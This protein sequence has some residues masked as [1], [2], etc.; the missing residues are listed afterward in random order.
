MPP[1][2][3]DA[4]RIAVEAHGNTQDKAGR[5]PYILHPMRV[6]LAQETE[7][8]RMVGILHDVVED[9]DVSMD[10]IVAMGF[11]NEVVEALKLVTHDDDGL[12][13]EEYINRLKDN[14]IARNVK[15]ADLEDNMNIRR[16]AELEAKDYE[17][18]KKY[19]VTWRELKGL[20]DKKDAVLRHRS[21]V[22]AKSTESDIEGQPFPFDGL[23]LRCLGTVQELIAGQVLGAVWLSQCGIYVITFPQGYVPEFIDKDEAKAVGN[24]IRPWSID[25]LQ[26]KWVPDTIVGYIGLAGRRQPRTLSERLGDLR[27][28]ASGKTTGNGPHKGGEIIWQLKG[29]MEFN[30]WV[31]PT[32]MPPTPRETEERLLQKF[33]SRHGKLPFA[34]RQF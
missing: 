32:G 5:E 12:S 33:H 29:H 28:H 8:A 21:D 1:T 4:I 3:A 7:H 14:P 15:I 20:P 30:I 23:D 10:D 11:P 16:L 6:M 24:V 19:M 26:D 13:Y 25:R 31:C 2:L 27:R 17:R 34:N 9:T 18:L 22:S